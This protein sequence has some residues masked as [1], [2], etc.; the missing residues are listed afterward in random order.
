MRKARKI[1]LFPC[2][3]EVHVLLAEHSRLPR[4][5]PSHRYKLVKCQPPAKTRS[6]HHDGI[7]SVRLRCQPTLSTENSPL[8]YTHLS[9]G[10]PRPNVC[11]S[12]QCLLSS[13]FYSCSY[14]WV[15]LWFSEGSRGQSWRVAS[16]RG[17]LI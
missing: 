13:P 4:L 1:R 15:S 7:K 14:I 8:S 16:S 6:S 12:R 9:N 2:A 11:C 3:L 17:I 10:F 5:P